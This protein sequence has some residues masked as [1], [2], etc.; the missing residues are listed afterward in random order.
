M[1]AG[2]AVV[3]KEVVAVAGVAAAEEGGQAAPRSSWATSPGRPPRTNSLASSQTS[4]QS[5]DSESFRTAKPEDPEVNQILN[6]V[7]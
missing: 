2:A 3:T 6:I 1:A 7:A 5:S 4:D